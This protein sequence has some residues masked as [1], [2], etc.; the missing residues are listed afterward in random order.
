MKLDLDDPIAVLLAVSRTFRLAGLDAAAYGGLAL[1]IYGKPRETKDADLAVLH[2]GAE[3]WRSVLT[4]GGLDAQVAFDRVRFGGNL[5]TRITL[6]GG[7]DTEGL[8]T[9]DLIEP[10][11]RRFAAGALARASEGSLRGETIRVVSPED[12][13]LLKVLSTRARDLEDAASVVRLLGAAFDTARVAAEGRLLEQEIADHPV[14]ARLGT[15]LESRDAP[16]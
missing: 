6:L 16:A 1:A 4:R 9:V 10:R 15:A 13:V 7:A 14:R 11:S 5:V 8:N 3:P 12:F 2:A